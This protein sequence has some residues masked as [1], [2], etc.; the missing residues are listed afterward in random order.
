METVVGLL[1]FDERE[2]AVDLKQPVVV[3][4]RG[5]RKTPLLHARQQRLTCH[6]PVIA[7][8]RHDQ[9]TG[10]PTLMGRNRVSVRSSLRYE[11]RGSAVNYSISVPTA[12]SG[13][14]PRFVGSTAPGL[15]SR[16]MTSKIACGLTAPM[17]RSRG[18]LGMVRSMIVEG[19]ELVT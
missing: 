1:E 7:N 17:R 9:E 16:P 10:M 19:S 6:R 18:S 4:P 15:M 3:E 5:I 11:V 8:H 12:A 2:V 13:C 14:L